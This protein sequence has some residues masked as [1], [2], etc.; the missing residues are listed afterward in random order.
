VTDDALEMALRALRHRDR[1]TAEVDRHLE[2]RGVGE[3]E[4]Q[5]VLETLGRT[6][7]V[8]DHR[9]AEARASSLADRGAGDVLIRHDLLRAGVVTD[10]VDEALATLASERERAE[11]I[12]ARRGGGARTARYLAGKGFTDD[13]VHAV[14]AEWPGETLG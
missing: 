5:R 2:A 7:L 13:V 14:V 11:L 6:G 3:S 8:D 9:Y 4:R 10:I 12:V 1:S